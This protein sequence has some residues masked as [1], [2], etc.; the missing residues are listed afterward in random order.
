M[1][2][3]FSVRLNDS[4]LFWCFQFDG[5]L[6]MGFPRIAVTGATPV[7]NNMIDQGLVE[8][9]VFAFWLNRE[10]GVSLTTVHFIAY[11]HR[12]L[13]SMATFNYFFSFHGK[14]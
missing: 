2:E 7:F 13:Y 6:G 11:T 12:F 3:R 5:I 14:V 1:V 9:P 4:Y 10:E 8:E